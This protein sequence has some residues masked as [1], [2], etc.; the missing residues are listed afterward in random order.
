ME[1][2]YSLRPADMK[3]AA[4]EDVS[5]GKGLT[6]SLPDPGRYFPSAM[7]LAFDSK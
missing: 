3:L 6:S 7:F 4:R 1:D 2:A 5:L